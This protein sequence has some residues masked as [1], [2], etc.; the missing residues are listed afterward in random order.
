MIFLV[1]RA[2]LWK[3]FPNVPEAFRDGENW[4]IQI[5]TIGDLYN[6]L[7]REGV[8]ILSP[9][10]VTGKSFPSIQVYDI[11]EHKNTDG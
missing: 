5:D 7:E 8:L 10:K 1:S 4:Y 6:F 11:Q 3:G 2:S 9:K